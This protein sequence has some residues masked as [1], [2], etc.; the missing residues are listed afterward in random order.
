MRSETAQ[1]N[2]N[3]LLAT[4]GGFVQTFLYGLSGLRVDVRGLTS[5]VAPVLPRELSYLK[6][7]NIAFRGQLYE[8]K[9]SRLPSGQVVRR[10]VARGSIH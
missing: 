9:I 1:N 5:A 2:S 6:L 10:M 4:S 3:Y 8:V 7:V